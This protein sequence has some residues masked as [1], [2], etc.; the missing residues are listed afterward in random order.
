MSY[1]NATKPV[2]ACRPAVKATKGH[3]GRPEQQPSLKYICRLS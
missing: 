2:P 1:F 3:K